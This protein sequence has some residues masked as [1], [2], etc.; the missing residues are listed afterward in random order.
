MTATAHIDPRLSWLEIE[1]RRVEQIERPDAAEY[2]VPKPIFGP[3][4]ARWPLDVTDARP[5]QQLGTSDEQR[6]LDDGGKQ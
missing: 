4:P 1:A 6:W 3:L 2:D 5:T